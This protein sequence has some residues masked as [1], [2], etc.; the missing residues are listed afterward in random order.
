M[1]GSKKKTC[2]GRRGRVDHNCGRFYSLALF[3]YF[4]STQVELRFF[5]V[6]EGMIWKSVDVI[7]LSSEKQVGLRSEGSCCQRYK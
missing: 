1:L 3:Y 7:N 5:R 6:I 2:T 4:I